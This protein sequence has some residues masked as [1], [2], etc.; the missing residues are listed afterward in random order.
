MPKILLIEDDNFFAGIFSKKLEQGGF[1]VSVANSGEDGLKLMEKE[2]PDLM[3]L[4]LILPKMNGFEVLERVKAS[5][6][7]KNFPVL[8]L[9]NLGQRED[10][11]KCLA[12]GAADYFIKAHVAPD[13]LVNKV[14]DVLK[15]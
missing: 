5:E 9:S 10:I 8:I 11:D 2:T 12:L 6:S 3:I 13:E 4:D 1:D 7:T 14:R 15:Q